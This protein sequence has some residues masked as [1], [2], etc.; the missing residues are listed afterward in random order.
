M[1]V[2]IG[3]FDEAMV[4]FREALTIDPGLREAQVN[5]DDPV[6]RSQRAAPR[7]R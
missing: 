6:A 4:Q 7:S 2:R 3:R 1:L 5:L